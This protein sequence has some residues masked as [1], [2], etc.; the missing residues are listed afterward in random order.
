[1]QRSRLLGLSLLLLI[2]GVGCH[3]RVMTTSNATSMIRRDE[4]RFTSGNLSLAATITRPT[5]GRRHPGV[6]VLHAA[7]L[8]R[9]ADYRTLADSLASRGIVVLAYDMRGAGDSEGEP[10]PPTFQQ[11]SQDA[12]AALQLLRAQTDVDARKVGLWA[13]SRG[14]Y[15]APIV[16]VADPDVRFLIVVSSTGLPVGRSDSTALVDRAKDNKL[17]A[18]DVARYERFV[19]L[20]FR[21]A[22][23]GGLDYERLQQEFDNL[24]A[25]PWFSALH[26]SLPPEEMWIRYG[27]QHRFDPDSV[28]RRVRIPTLLIYGGRDAPRLVRDSRTRILAGLAAAG[29]P[30]D[31]PVYADADHFITVAQAGGEKRFAPGFFDLHHQWIAAN[32]R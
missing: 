20:L 13:L 6:V 9:R 14:G 8:D 32:V 21:A 24:K 25:Q 15:T 18:G 26:T 29:A 16:A 2:A 1:M 23:H 27:R 10:G 19:G 5:D 31:A 7:G 11:L 4:V 28:W 12:Q 30:V 3:R 17:V 22:R